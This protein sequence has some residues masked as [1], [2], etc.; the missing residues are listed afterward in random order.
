LGINYNFETKPVSIPETKPI[1]Q[2][3]I[4]KEDKV[5]VDG[6]V[7]SIKTRN[8]K[9][10]IAGFKEDIELMNF[11]ELK[12]RIQKLNL[13]EKEEQFISQIIHD[14]NYHMILTISDLL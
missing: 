5:T 14:K 12:E 3:E 13:N 8:S 1:I 7:N 6:F 11:K 9:E 2:K 10:F 4:S